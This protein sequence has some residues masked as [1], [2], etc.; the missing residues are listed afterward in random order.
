MNLSADI[1]AFRHFRPEESL[2]FRDQ[3]AM[4]ALLQEPQYRENVVQVPQRWFNAYQGE[5]NETLAPLQIHR[6]DLLVHFAGVPNREARLG[7]WRDRAERHLEE[8]EVPV[9]MA[10]LP[11]EVADYWAELRGLREERRKVAAAARLEAGL[12]LEEIERWVR[13]FGERVGEGVRGSVREK[14]EGSRAFLADEGVNVDA[15]KIGVL[16]KE[17]VEAAAPLLEAQT[18]AYKVLLK[19]AHDAVFGAEKLLLEVGYPEKKSTLEIMSL[20]QSVEGLKA[21]VIVPEDKWDRKQIQDAMNELTGA[22]GK[23]EGK[24]KGEERKE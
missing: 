7:F 9:K 4:S 18:Q 11:T 21:L 3:S 17:M 2:V 14:M 1:V 23:V 8:W 13:E 15:A 24:V 5:H 20:A 19:G 6:G 22:K 16:T 10:S 12:R